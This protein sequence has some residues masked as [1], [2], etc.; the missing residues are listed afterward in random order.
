MLWDSAWCIHLVYPKIGRREQG[1][2]GGEA[3]FWVVSVLI[4]SSGFPY[5]PLFLLVFP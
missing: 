4:L 5:S 1:E 2:H 3:L